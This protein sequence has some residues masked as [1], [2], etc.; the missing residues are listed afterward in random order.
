MAVSEDDMA[1]E[2]VRDSKEVMLGEIEEEAAK[3][4]YYLL[5]GSGEHRLGV[6]G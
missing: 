1:A 2:T 6:L 5:R 4:G 3:R